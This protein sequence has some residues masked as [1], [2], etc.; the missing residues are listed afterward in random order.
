MFLGEYSCIYLVYMY[1]IKVLL[2]KWKEGE[3]GVNT[4][5]LSPKSNARDVAMQRLYIPKINTKNP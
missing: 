2:G 3:L 4:V 5:Q 1:Y